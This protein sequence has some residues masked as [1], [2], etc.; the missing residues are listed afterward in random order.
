M[1]NPLKR[2]KLRR[3]P[4]KDVEIDIDNE[5]DVQSEIENKEARGS[6]NH[7]ETVEETEQ[8]Q[9][10]DE[11][12]LDSVVIE[13][14]PQTIYGVRFPWEA[15]FFLIIG[16]LSEVA[17]ALFMVQ[18]LNSLQGGD[19]NISLIISFIVGGGCFFSMAFIGFQQANRRYYSKMGV[20]FSYFF[21]ITA[22]AALVATKFLGGLKDSG[23]S[24]ALMGYIPFN[25]VIS[26]DKFI[27]S[28]TI[29]VVQMV[30]YI[31]T[32]FMT[33]DSVR[34]LTD[35]DLR[36]Y[37]L[38]RKKFGKLLKKLK[39]ER[40]DIVE[41]IS[42]LK[43]YPKYASRLARSKKSVQRNIRQYNESARALVEAKM[44]ITVEPDLMED[45]YDKT[46]DKEEKVNKRKENKI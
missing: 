6:R 5:A 7:E 28:A 40:G 2:F 42:I 25:E 44:A 1:R 35:N 18:S 21:W 9:L 29:G 27:S 31:G 3:I 22:G 12:E 45:I 34:M 24:E 17:D 32:G 10:Q 16:I 20:G 39:K 26:N 23:L 14:M 41:D 13:K 8:E 43:A 37:F 4:T 11:K 15:V 46:M 38:A 36:E 19:Q 30:L 33:R